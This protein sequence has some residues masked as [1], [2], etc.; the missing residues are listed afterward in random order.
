MYHY[1]HECWSKLGQSVQQGCCNPKGSQDFLF[2]H[3]F[4]FLILFILFFIVYN[5]NTKIST[6]GKHLRGQYS[7]QHNVFD[8]CKLQSK[9][10]ASLLRFTSQISF[11]ILLETNTFPA[12]SDYWYLFFLKIIF[13]LFVL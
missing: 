2:L 10:N 9:A 3:F 5:T 6:E 7:T 1:L 11:E 12:C 4:F 13:L 8:A